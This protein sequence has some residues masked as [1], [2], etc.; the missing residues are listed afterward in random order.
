MSNCWLYTPWI[1]GAAISR[2]PPAGGTAPTGSRC[3]SICITWPTGARTR[4]QVRRRRVGLRRRPVARSRQIFGRV[5]GAARRPLAP[6]DHSTAGAVEASRRWQGLARPL[7]FVVAGHHAGLADG[8]GGSGRAAVHPCAIGWRPH[9]RSSAYAGEIE[10][11]T[12]LPP[13]A[14]HRTGRRRAQTGQASRLRSS[15]ACCSPAWSTPTTW[16]PKRL[17]PGRGAADAAGRAA[18]LDDLKAKLDAY[19]GRPRCGG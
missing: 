9:C 12:D 14:W 6:V 19:L 8:G 4:G 18:A 15:P 11:P 7:Q 13:P 5:P 1:P 17:R 3:A 16:T 2:I 10:L